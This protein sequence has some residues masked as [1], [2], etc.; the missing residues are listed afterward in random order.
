MKITRGYKVLL[1]ATDFL[2]LFFS[3]R[4]CNNIVTE[5]EMYFP[6]Q[7]NMSCAMLGGSCMFMQKPAGA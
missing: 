1:F 3:N 4:F 6:E 2:K 5:I 7:R